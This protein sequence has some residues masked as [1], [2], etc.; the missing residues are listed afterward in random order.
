MAKEASITVRISA[1]LKARLDDAAH[2]A[3]RSTSSL[4][5]SILYDWA[6]AEASDERPKMS[7]PVGRPRSETTRAQALRSAGTLLPWLVPILGDSD[8]ITVADILAKG[9]RPGSPPPAAGIEM[10]IATAL[11]GLGWTERDEEQ[12]DGSVQKVWTR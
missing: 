11:H 12:N 6:G 3:H 7:R 8:R 10:G 4:V 5:T 2:A 1:D 9:Q